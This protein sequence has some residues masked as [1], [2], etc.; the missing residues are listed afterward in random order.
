MLVN[1]AYINSNKDAFSTQDVPQCHMYPPFQTHS[2][3]QMCTKNNQPTNKQKTLFKNEAI[4]KQITTKKK[5]KK[6]QIFDINAFGWITD[7]RLLQYSITVYSLLSHRRKIGTLFRVDPSNSVLFNLLFFDP[8]IPSFALWQCLLGKEMIRVCPIA[9]SVL[10]ILSVLTWYICD[11]YLVKF[12]VNDIHL[13]NNV[14]YNTPMFRLRL[15][16]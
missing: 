1:T 15:S 8:L 10:A 16:A 14:K 3:T 11:Y 7:S 13:E 4:Q 9:C 2:A 6:V 5:K 12:A